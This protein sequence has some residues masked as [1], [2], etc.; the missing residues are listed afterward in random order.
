[1]GDAR[2]LADFVFEGGGVKDIGL[3]GAYSVLSTRYRPANVAGTSAE[4]IV[5]ALVAAGYTAAEMQQIMHDLDFDRFQDRGAT[6]R[7][8]LLGPLVSLLSEKGV[9]EG[10]FVERWM[11]ELLREKGVAEFGELRT[12]DPDERYRYTLNVI[13]ADVTRGRLVVLPQGLAADGED[14]DR[15][16]VARAVRMSM[17]IPPPAWPTFGVQL[18]E[19]DDGKPRDIDGPVDFVKAVVATM[20]EAHD[21]LHVEDDDIPRTIRVPTDGV[22]TTEVDLSDNRK[23]RLFRSGV[24]AA[25]RFLAIWSFEQYRER[26]R[27]RRNPAWVAKVSHLRQ[28][29]VWWPAAGARQE[30]PDAGAGFARSGAGPPRPPRPRGSVRLERHV[31]ADGARQSARL[32]SDAGTW[33][34]V[35]EDGDEVMAGLRSFARDG[36]VAA[37][38]FAAVGAFRDVVLGYVDWARRDCA[39]VVRHEPLQVV[40]LAGFVRPDDGGARAPRVQAHVVL[41]RPDGSAIVGH[42]LEGRVGRLLELVLRSP[43][44]DATRRRRLSA[45]SPSPG[46]QHRCAGRD[47]LRAGLRIL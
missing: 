45:H 34:L 26:Y 29:L 13:T 30:M 25:E 23:R 47:C 17:S 36:G 19:P 44:R 9:Y 37:S 43:A 11:R 32:G 28:K 12:E 20:L 33:V 31:H 21:K 38:D 35:F 5:G 42:L 22:G 7:V 14:P 4:A 40:A 27:V 41:E 3:V 6:D 2:Q 24:E 46:A 15:L 1:M 10:R 18:I 8:P 16:E 39:R